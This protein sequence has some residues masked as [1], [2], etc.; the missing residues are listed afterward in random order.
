MLECGHRFLR[1]FASRQC[2]PQSSSEAAARMEPLRRKLSSGLIHG[3]REWPSRR[4]GASLLSML[5]PFARYWHRVFQ[6]PEGPRR[7]A[8]GELPEEPAAGLPS[9][10]HMRWELHEI[11]MRRRLSAQKRATAE[12]NLLPCRPES[13]DKARRKFPHS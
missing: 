12:E 10:R 7:P 5:A 6:K 2:D 4:S 9:A 3:P 8:W 1:G 13:C 11:N